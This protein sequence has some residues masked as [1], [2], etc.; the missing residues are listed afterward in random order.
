MRLPSIADLEVGG[1]TVLLRTDFDIPLA[2]KGKEIVVADETR[3]SL[4]L[5]TINNLLK[6]KAKIVIIAHLG[7]PQGKVN[8]E[9]SLRPTITVLSSLLGNK[10]KVDFSSAVL[11]EELKQQVAAFQGEILVLENL[12]FYQEEENNDIN[13]AKF[14]A[15]LAQL[16]INEAFAAS[17]RQHASIVGIPAFLPSVFGFS[18][19]KEVEVLSEVYRQP[20]RPVMIILGGKKESKI[21][22]GSRLLEWADK[23]LVGGSLVRSKMMAGFGD[24]KKVLAGLSQEG[25]DISLESA[26]KFAEILKNAGTIIWSGPMGAYEDSRYL[27]GTEIIS[28]AIVD[29]KAFSVIGGGDTEAALTKLGLVSKIDYVSSGGGAMLEFLA[30]KKLPGLVALE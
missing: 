18:F 30:G 5:K 29:S 16:F 19:L 1:K 4:S 12:R 10:V 23:I 28:R 14:L 7:R 3:L 21:S 2:K 27:K 15:G 20:K 11:G 26:G 9:L 13:F 6:N 8:Q 25:M 24:H 17:H 22:S